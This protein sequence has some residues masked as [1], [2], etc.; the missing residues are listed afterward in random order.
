MDYPIKS[1]KCSVNKVMVRFKVLFY[2]PKLT[3]Q[4]SKSKTVLKEEY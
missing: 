4:T 3:S 1:D 2:S